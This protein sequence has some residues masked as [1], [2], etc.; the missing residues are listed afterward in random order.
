MNF[1]LYFESKKE[2]IEPAPQDILDALSSE[3]DEDSKLT[4][5][6]VI[7]NYTD[8][9]DIVVVRCKDLFEDLNNE[10]LMVYD[11]PNF[12]FEGYIFP[13]EPLYKQ[14]MTWELTSKLAPSTKETFGDLVDEL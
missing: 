8:S 3:Y 14:I 11:L 7:K 1:K 13:G 2:V 9:G 4:K 10:N 6:W 12:A 5:G